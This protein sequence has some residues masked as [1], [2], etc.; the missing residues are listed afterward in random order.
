MSSGAAGRLGHGV[1][2]P[3]R[4]EGYAPIREYAA[5]G[6]GRTVA[7]VARDGSVDWLCLPDL[8]SPSV[9]GA[10]LDARRGGRFALAPDVPYRV[11]RRY[12]PGTNVLETTFATAVGTVRV[13]DA[14]TLCGTGFVPPRELAR[15]VEG[16][17]GRVPMRWSVEPRF[18]Y[19]GWRT[20]LERRE[21]MP[22]ATAG[23]TALAVCAYAAGEPVIAGGSMSGCFEAQAGSTALVAVC[24]AHQEPLVL[25]ARPDVEARLD[26]T[27]A[28]WRRWGECSGYDG[29]WRE[30]VVRSALALKLLIFAPSGAVAAAATTSLPEE[31]GGVRNW[32]YR[33]CWVRDSALV[34]DALLSLACGAESDAFFW[35]LMHASQ[36][37]HPRLQ[38]LYRLNGGAR[39]G[40]RAL[41][42]EGYRRSAPVRVGNGAIDQLQ[43]DVYGDLLQTAWLYHRAGRTLDP[44]LGRRLA[45]VAD[46]IA[47]WWRR[48]DSGIWEVRSQPLHFTQSKMLCW[49]ALDRARRLAH[50][51]VIPGGHA[52]R[53]EAEREAIRAFVD[54][55]CWSEAKRSYVRYAGGE[56]LDASVLLGIIFGYLDGRSPRAQGTIDALRRELGRGPHLYRYS[57]EDGLPGSEGV[58]ITCSFWLVEALAR[59]GRIAEAVETMDQLVAL[60]N[61]VGLYAEELDPATGEFLGNFPQGLTHLALINAAT[62]VAEEAER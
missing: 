23:S 36:L 12:R 1:E 19:G 42:L 7:L 6:D 30:A 44:D 58:F 46:L 22:V 18:G 41:P 2:V 25:P 54:T 39:A 27:A 56:E 9:F 57:G 40:E 5:L 38:V 31:L 37:T 13:T 45:E 24:A 48:P 28:R 8:D 15:R 20:R 61:D 60:A 52:I 34:L 17:S 26:D 32:D 33:F 3:V 35:W 10:L 49:V 11:A 4:V 51:G 62:A 47:R 50:A 43:L 55:Q 53:W 21:G 16:L 29:P 14:M 59:A